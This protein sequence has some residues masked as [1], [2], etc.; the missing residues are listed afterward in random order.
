MLK[1]IKV[2]MIDDGKGVEFKFGS[3]TIGYDLVVVDD[4]YGDEMLYTGGLE[5]VT[6]KEDKIVIYLRDRKI[7][8]ERV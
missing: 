8:L 5:E 4:M 2:L 7:V 1:G 6:I 3:M